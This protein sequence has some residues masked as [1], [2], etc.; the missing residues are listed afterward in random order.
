MYRPLA[1]GSTQSELIS[2]DFYFILLS[3]SFLLHWPQNKF[4]YHYWLMVLS[5][6]CFSCFHLYTPTLLTLY[7]CNLLYILIYAHTTI[8][9][10]SSSHSSFNS[11]ATTQCCSDPCSE[12]HSFSPPASFLSS[13]PFIYSA[14]LPLKS[15]QFSL[16]SS[17]WR[18]SFLYFCKLCDYSNSN[19]AQMSAPGQIRQ[20][21]IFEWLLRTLKYNDRIKT[22]YCFPQVSL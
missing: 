15:T 17:V 12:F 7:L 5:L 10:L 3:H 6:D 19:Y 16:G 20:L 2:R 22:I 4:T 9:L 14:F 18:E 13:S 1:G 11:K 8:W 21:I